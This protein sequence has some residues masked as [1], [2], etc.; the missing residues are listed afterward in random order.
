VDHTPLSLIPYTIEILDK[1]A[2]NLF[3][4]VELGSSISLI[5]S[6]D[7]KYSSIKRA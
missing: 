4:G 1:V 3:V 2:K 7:E 6:S 5:G